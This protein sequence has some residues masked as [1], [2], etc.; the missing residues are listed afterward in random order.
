[1]IGV[2]AL[3]G[4]FE[5]HLAALARAGA[6]AHEVRTAA[7]VLESD[8]LVI[9][10][11][12]STTLRK[13]MEGTGIEDAIRAAALRGDAVLGTCAGAILLADAVT[14][15]DARGLGLLAVRIERNAYGRQLDSTVLRLTDVDHAVLG[16]EPLEAVFIRAPKITEAGPGVEVLARRDGDP[17]LVRK[18]NILAATFHPE[19][20]EDRRVVDLFLA[21][22]MTKSVR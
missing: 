20:S 21:A 3:Q 19:L 16:P 22:R 4:D 9:P 8:G 13:L 10:G 12:E 2:L 5:A 18:A 6:P 15:P 14:N 7:E 1:M 11:G 17:V